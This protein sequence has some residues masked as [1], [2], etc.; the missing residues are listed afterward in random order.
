M[1]PKVH[2]SLRKFED[3]INSAFPVQ[4]TRRENGCYIEDVWTL[5]FLYDRDFLTPPPKKKK[6]Q[7]SRVSGLAFQIGFF[8][9][10]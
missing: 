3:K 2:L 1:L 4:T 6:N 7:P 10:I 5:T 9:K 8:A